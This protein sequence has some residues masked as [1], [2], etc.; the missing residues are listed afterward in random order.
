MLSNSRD[1]IS[2]KLKTESKSTNP[3]KHIF[4]LVPKIANNIEKLLK[5][6]DGAVTKVNS[7]VRH[8]Q[9]ESDK[10]VDVYEE[11]DNYINKIIAS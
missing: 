9:I 2:D 5:K 10:E 4:Q 6:H 3:D 8:V 11:V 7:S 1:Y